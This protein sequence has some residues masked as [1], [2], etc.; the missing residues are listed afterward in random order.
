VSS[1]INEVYDLKEQPAPPPPP[2]ATTAEPVVM[3]RTP[4]LLPPITTRRMHH[5]AQVTTWVMVGI[6]LL[7]GA[8]WAFR[9]GMELRKEIWQRTR[10]IRF[11]QDIG[12]GFDF[13]NRALR[14]AEQQAGLEDKADALADQS[15]KV[16]ARVG[17]QPRLTSATF[18]RLTPRELINGLVGYVDSVAAAGGDYDL[19]YCPLRLAVMTLWTRHVQRLRPDM[20]SFPHDRVDDTSLG[21]EEDVAEPVLKLNAYCAAAGAVLMFFLVLVWVNRSF[22][23]ARPF[24]LEW[25]YRKWRGLPKWTPAMAL[26]PD[27]SPRWAWTVPHGIF[28]FMLSCGGFWYAYV[29][30]V[31]M[32]PRPPPAISVVQV[33]P[34]GDSATIVANI[35]SQNQD[36]TWRVDYGSGAAYGQ[37]TGPQAA[38][39]SLADQQLAVKLAQL[40]AGQIVHF[41]VVATSAGGTISTPDYSFVNG[42]GPID[43]YGETIGGIDWPIW[44]VWLR[45]LALFIIM[46]VSAQMLPPIHRGWACGAVAAMLVWLDPITLIDSHAWPQW[47]VWIVPFIIGMALFASL[48]WW[49]LAGVLFGMGCLLKG[50]MLLGAPFFI[51]WP[52]LEGRWGALWRICMGFLL[53]IE[54]VTWPW[55]VNSHDELRWIGMAMAGALLVMGVSWLR[56]PIVRSARYWVIDPIIASR[57][58]PMKAEAE[59]GPEPVIEILQ[60]AAVLAA[61]VVAMVLV[62]VKLR[63]HRADL[64]AGALSIFLLI[65]LVPP[66][67]LK[68]KKLGY[69]LAGIFA[70]AVLI[71]SAAFGGSYSWA[72]IGLHYGAMRHD[73]IQMSTRNLSNLA[74]VLSQSYGWDIHDAM[75]TLKLAFKTPGP[76]RL[77]PIA[78]PSVDKTWAFDLDVK[79]ATAL[80]YGLCLFAS[81]AAAALHHRRNDRRF[82]V[83]LAVPWVVFPLVMCQMG[84]RYPIWAAAVSAGMVAVSLELTLLHV[85]LTVAAFAMVARQLVNFEPS[86]WPQLMNFTTPWFPGVGWL[87][88]FVAAIFVFAALVPSRKCLGE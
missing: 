51:L 55:L 61:I 68:R 76:W 49:M 26:E 75:G 74:S 23:P 80:L 3:K 33:Q 82:L 58:S 18:R 48:N 13:G 30:L 14:F 53:G 83:A 65:M 8:V 41:K 38:D 57:K 59:P 78:I 17:A 1:Q 56:E 69:W 39:S 81:A 10:S 11:E 29:E 9:S 85:V 19:D 84:D 34:G 52:F 40:T 7:N 43:I 37:T 44:T 24:V 31:H 6:F 2:R 54:I 87:M 45:L 25:W 72:E 70:L 15:P 36:T 73:Q 12:R 5:V 28:A 67:L 47:D 77:G 60:L 62:L 88:V 35:N 71:G 16:L 27:R 46:V 63:N 42:G 64:P 66:F 4:G 86:R 79:S 22:R 50:Q 21:Q 20:D 32:P